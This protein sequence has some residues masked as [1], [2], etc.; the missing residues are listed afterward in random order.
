MDDSYI[1]VGDLSCFS[2]LFYSVYPIT[3]K[4]EDSKVCYN[5]GQTG[6]LNAKIKFN[7]KNITKYAMDQR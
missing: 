4:A 6:T 5:S 3:L 7:G 1:C 2:N